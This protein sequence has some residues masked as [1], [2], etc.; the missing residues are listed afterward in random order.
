MHPGLRNR[1]NLKNRYELVEALRFG[2]SR[3]ERHTQSLAKA[4]AE[5]CELENL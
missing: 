5:R 4:I 3:N 1:V 2:N